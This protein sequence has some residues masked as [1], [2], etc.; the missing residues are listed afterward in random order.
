MHVGCIVWNAVFSISTAYNHLAL[1]S[2]GHETLSI[3]TSCTDY[4]ILWHGFLITKHVRACRHGILGPATNISTRGI[5]RRLES[6]ENV[7]GRGSAPDPAGGAQNA[8]QITY[9][10]FESPRMI[11]CLGFS[12]IIKMTSRQFTTNISTR[13]IPRRLESTEIRIFGWGS[14]PDPLADLRTLPQTS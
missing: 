11:K 13:G 6:T 10:R 2:V 8:T 4:Q 1:L 14:T 3:L 5:L 9:S 7:F 12:S